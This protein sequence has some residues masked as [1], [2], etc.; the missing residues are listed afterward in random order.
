[1]GA[2]LSLTGTYVTLTAQDKH[3]I[4]IAGKLPGNQ[5]KTQEYMIQMD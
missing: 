2:D 1:M 4:L 5:T 3:G